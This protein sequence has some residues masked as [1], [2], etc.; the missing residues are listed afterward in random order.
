[1]RAFLLVVLITALVVPAVAHHS[2]YTFYYMDKMMEIEGTVKS[3][4]IVNPH[5]EM[6][7]EVTDKDGTKVLWRITATAGGIVGLQKVG[8]KAGMLVGTRVKV[9]GHPPRKEGGTGLAG[10]KV[11]LLEKATLPDGKEY[12]AGTVLWLGGGGGIPI[13]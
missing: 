6:T 13:G 9:E 7:V 3:L 11:T 4:K 1:M 8:W 2:F 12:P 5:S 10:G